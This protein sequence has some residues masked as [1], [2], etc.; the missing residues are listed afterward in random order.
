MFVQQLLTTKGLTPNGIAN[1]LKKPSIQPA[2][3][4]YL[5]GK[6]IDPRN[7]WV[8][9]VAR[10]LDTTAEAFRSEAAAEAEALRIGLLSATSAA[11]TPI[12]RK[13][14]VTRIDAGILAIQ[15]GDLMRDHDEHVRAAAAALFSGAASRPDE[16]VKMAERLRGLL[17]G[18]DVGEGD[19]RKQVT[20]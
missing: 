1:K 2:L 20:A 7:S 3:S 15:I 9:P 19:S 5:A 6:T 14:A 16:A 10:Y 17:G 18:A 12:H 11:P 8:A 4:R 13:R